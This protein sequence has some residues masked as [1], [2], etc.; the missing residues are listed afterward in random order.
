M[1]IFFIDI[2]AYGECGV[3]GDSNERAGFEIG[4]FD[5]GGTLLNLIGVCVEDIGV[6]P[7]VLCVR[8]MV[9]VAV[10][11]GESIARARD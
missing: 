3:E 1:I 5:A 2:I 4:E 7:F 9:E 11:S 6:F 8:D 10:E